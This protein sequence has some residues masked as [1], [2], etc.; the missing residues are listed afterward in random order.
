MASLFS[1]AMLYLG[2]TEEEPDQGRE[3]LAH[4]FEDTP[5]PTA[6]PEPM[7][8]RRIE[9][10]ATAARN[11]TMRPSY[12]VSGVVRS[13]RSEV[14]ADILVV[15][16]FADARILADRVRDRVPVV[17]DLRRVDG[18]L[19]RRVIDFSSGLIYALDGTMSRVGDGLVLVLP[20][21]IDLSDN[22]KRRLASLGAFEIDS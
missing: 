16:E 17:L 20:P 1:K 22:E 7:Q 6:P 21:G 4:E 3:R 5:Y 18:D 8:G 11:T 9:P 14:Q 12:G 2:L 13:S 19:L 10:P 15:E